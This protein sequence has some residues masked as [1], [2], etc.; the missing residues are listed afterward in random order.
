M[1][2]NVAH[3]LI[4][5]FDLLGLQCS[6]IILSSLFTFILKHYHSVQ[7]LVICQHTCLSYIHNRVNLLKVQRM[8]TFVRA[9]L[10][11][12]PFLKGDSLLFI[13][14]ICIQI[15]IFLMFH[16]CVFFP[17]RFFFT[18]F[19]N[20][21]HIHPRLFAMCPKHLQYNYIHFYLFCSPHWMQLYLL[22]K[23]F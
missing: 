12:L 1:V 13:S 14:I 21:F 7:Y 11:Y 5:L 10:L 20:L 6:L 22:T 18:A 4:L 19:T 8:F 2:D 9:F 17:K 23:V 3:L 15:Y 16:T